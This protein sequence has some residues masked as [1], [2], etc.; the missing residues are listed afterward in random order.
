MENES[1]GK[2]NS[3]SL[4]PGVSATAA[5]M[6]R[7]AVNTAEDVRV[8][9]ANVAQTAADKLQEQSDRMAA[10]LD[11]AEWGLHDRRQRLAN[12]AQSTADK[13]Q[14]VANYLHEN[15]TNAMADDVKDLI[16]RNPAPWLIAAAV[17]GFLIAR[18]F[19][20]ED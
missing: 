3:G 14:S 12:A 18:L 19:Q 7:Q 10:T 2:E 1:S 4:S 13:L 20:R 17:A 6:K 5:K 16:R 8:K 15:D 9:A 11:R